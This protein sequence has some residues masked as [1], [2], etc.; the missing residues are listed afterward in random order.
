VKNTSLALAIVA[1][2]IPGVALAAKPPAPGN[3]QNNHSKAAPKVMYV[4][5][6]TLAAYT[7][8][9]TAFTSPASYS[10]P[11]GAV[12]IDIKSANHHGAA[13]KALTPLAICLSPTT[14]VVVKGGGSLTV[15]D[16]GIVKLRYA[17][18]FNPGDP[19]QLA[20]FLTTTTA[21]QI[22]DQGPTS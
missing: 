12:T 4:L 15:G 18:R 21:K 22:I 7:Q 5:R 17:K 14:R 19:S 9:A 20:A 13:L 6:G 16:K 3:S 11:A 10:C 8:T 2:L 1:L